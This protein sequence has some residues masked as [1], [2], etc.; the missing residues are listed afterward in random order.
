ME[1]AGLDPEQAARIFDSI[2]SDKDNATHPSARRR[3]QAIRSL[4][5]K[6]AE[7]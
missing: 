7:G 2:G 6:P 1:K 4:M 3:A 5:H